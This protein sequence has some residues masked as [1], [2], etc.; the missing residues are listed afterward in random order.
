MLRS[1]PR[2][3][4][5]SSLLLA[6]GSPLSRGRAELKPVQFH[7]NMSSGGRDERSVQYTGGVGAHSRRTSCTPATPS[8]NK[9]RPRQSGRP[10]VVRKAPDPPLT[11]TSEGTS[12]RRR[13]WH[14]SERSE[15]AFA[16][17]AF[18]ELAFASCASSAEMALDLTVRS[19]TALYRTP[20]CLVHR[21]RQGPC[22]IR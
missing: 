6:A 8:A 18:A 11:P 10:E 2:R 22:G 14:R 17:P 7:R 19:M 12:V 4:E 16:E 1:F 5:S 15:L 21:T 3:R 9:P 13:I 20:H